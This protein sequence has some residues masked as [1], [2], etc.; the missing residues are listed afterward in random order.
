M[1]LFVLETRENCSG[2][3]E[4]KY[5]KWGSDFDREFRYFGVF[6]IKIAWSEL[7]HDGK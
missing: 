4:W 6:Q 2:N 7:A 5:N 1:K 3:L